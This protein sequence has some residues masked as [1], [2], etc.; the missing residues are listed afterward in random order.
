MPKY[1][2]D[3]PRSFS[4]TRTSRL[5]TQTRSTGP[6]SRPRGKSMPRKRRLASAST[7]RLRTRQYAKKDSSRILA[8]SPGWIWKKLP[9]RIHNFAPLTS[10]RLAGSTAG[11]ITSTMPVR[12]RVYAYRD[13]TRWSRTAQGAPIDTMTAASVQISWRTPSPLS[14][15]RSARCGAEV[16]PRS[17]RRRKAT[18]SP[19]SS[20]TAGR[21]AG[22]A[23]GARNRSP[24]CVARNTSRRR[25][26]CIQ[27]SALTF[28]TSAYSTAPAYA[29]T[30]TMASSRRTSSRLRRV[31]M[32]KPAVAL[33]ADGEA[34]GAA[35]AVTAAG[36]PSGSLTRA[37]A[38]GRLRRTAHARVGC[39]RGRG[40]RRAGRGASGD[41]RRYGR[42]GRGRH[43]AGRGTARRTGRT[44]RLHHVAVLRLDQIVVDLLGVGHAAGRD[45]LLDAV[46]RHLG[47]LVQGHRLGV[48]EP[49]QVQAGDLA[50]DALVHRD[51][52][53]GRRA[54]VVL[55]LAPR[56]D[57]PD[58]TAE[59][60]EQPDQQ[61]GGTDGMPLGPLGR[62]LVGRLRY[63]RAR[64]L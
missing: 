61:H 49:G 43:G 10:E 14:A 64:R 34:R 55:P 58:A 29:V 32:R 35:D 63:G 19:L 51:G 9:N 45:A 38:R 53:F 40:H 26:G 59:D 5:S 20:A 25:N 28:P 33:G 50:G 23:Y 56:P 44:G 60:R 39:W 2:S 3:V 13:S 7:S 4:N 42:G 21:I 18:P 41:A 31:G 24:T 8:N 30:T 1:I 27:K 62:L 47:Q 12:P 16:R 17:S 6:R 37:D 48:V 22:S 11:I 54:D 15:P 52:T 57:V 36:V 46:L